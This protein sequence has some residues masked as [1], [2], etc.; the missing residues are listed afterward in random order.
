VKL[1]VSWMREFSDPPAG[2]AEIAARMASCGFAVDSL[3]H[4]VIDFEVTANRPDALSIYGLAREIATLYDVPLAAYPPAVSPR[5]AG[6]RVS[7]PGPAPN[8]RVSI[9]SPLSARY[10]LAIASVTIGPS[11][12][13]VVERLAA[14]GVR[15]VNNIVDLTNYVMIEMGQPMHAFDANRLA[16][17]EI[18]VRLAHKGE[19]LTTLDGESR[20]L[21][22][23]ML[24]IADRDHA[25]AV[26]GVMGGRASEVSASTRH[27]A[28]ESAW[29]SP[30]SVR[31]TSK[32]LGL[33]TEASARFERGAD[34]DAPV[35]GAE[36]LLDLIEA[37]GAG[38]RAGGVHDDYPKPVGPRTVT[39]RKSMA[40]RLLGAAAPDADIERMLSKLGFVLEKTGEGWHA[41]V[42][43]FRVDVHREADVIE[44]IGRHYGFDRIPSTYP[45]P[46]AAPAPSSPRLR[47]SRDLRRVLAGAGLDEAVTFTFLERAA[48]ASFVEDE[49]ALVPIANP[50]SE[51][52]A[53]LRPSLL[54]GLVDACGYNQ[55]REQ[56]DV[57]LFEIGGAFSSVE[58]ERLQLGWA[59]S[60]TRHEHWSQPGRPTDYFDGSG[61]ADLAAAVF[62]VQLRAEPETVSWGVA[63]QTAR[64]C[65]RAAAGVPLGVIGQVKPSIV[66]ARGGGADPI[67]AG[68]LWLDRLMV[69]GARDRGVEPLPR[70][71]S[72]VRDLS[73]LVD[74]RLPAETVRVT[75]RAHAPAT[76]EDVR[77][78][79]RY[80]GKGIPEG[81]VSLSLR[82]T[83]RHPERTLTDEEASQAIEAIVAALMREHGAKLR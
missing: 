27:I 75:I 49:S 16:G 13:W 12:S 67:V 30:A 6:A 39:V 19:K 40:A 55:R 59:L 1:P 29:F 2:P 45:S 71:P 74:E 53:V 21:D 8:I 72:I 68:F 5:N 61:I 36:R 57:R 51:K 82:L 11:P 34:I 62:G 18:H 81:H 44:E 73:I 80:R 58:G 31:A 10:A 41:R 23:D 79:D 25:A 9:D 15:S 3:E 42:P 50:L 76:L 20:T 64:L 14:C 65:D 78:F 43:S 28:I 33:K 56:S 54:A 7:T 63:G 17:G 35:R 60:G 77:E 69:S 83:F 38:H 47:A 4:D 37:T 70:F 52:F 26:A 66:A 24:V 32:R 48:A 46:S 22:A